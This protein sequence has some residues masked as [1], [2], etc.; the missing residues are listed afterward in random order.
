MKINLKLKEAMMK[1]NVLVSMIVFLLTI[2][3]ISNAMGENVLRWANQ[4]DAVTFDP[5]SAA[6]SPTFVQLKQVYEP[7]VNFTPDLKKEPAL[8]TSWKMVNPTTWEFKIRQ[9]VS[10]H[11]GAKLTA[12]DVVFSFNRANS[13]GSDMKPILKDVQSTEL[14]DDYTVHIITKVPNPIFPDLLLP[15][16][17]MSKAWCEKHG[18]TEVTDWRTGQES[19]AVRHANGTGA[20]M[21]Q[22]REPDIKTVMVKNPNWW[23]L[24]QK[25]HNID[26]IIYT[27]IANPA[28]RVAALLSGEIDLLMDPP[29]QDLP[30]IKNDVNLKIEQTNQLRTIFFGLEQSR[31]EL[32]SSNIKGK[33][34]F[35]D[36]R[37]RKAMHMAIDINGIKKKVMRDLSIPANIIVPPGI[38]GYPEDLDK[39]RPKYD[40]Q[41]AKTLLAEAG[42]PDGFEVTLD[43]PNDRYIN[44]EKISQAVVGMLAKIGIIVN[45]SSQPKSLHFPKIINKK[46]DFY[47]LGWGFAYPDALAL[48][49]WMYDSK[50]GWNAGGI[51]YPRVDE[52]ITAMAQEMDLQKRDAMIREVFEITTEEQVYL[53]LHHQVLVWAMN[54]NLDFQIDPRNEPEFCRARF[55]K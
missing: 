4:G 45:L 9:G 25:P 38:H 16:H 53:P 42:Y 19:Y 22:S 26:K 52:L 33:N 15:I 18:V 46:T 40:I 11:D 41:K 50:S 12:A 55:N 8:A 28:T 23:G 51:S 20:F 21:L 36:A 5:A 49:A 37:V 43:S 39:A 31:D 6:M 14:I 13:A 2:T 34:P 48:F 17:I 10:F 7:L 44:D 54:K 30:R 32:R 1:K 29:I 35:K 27:P 24:A 47:M 3:V